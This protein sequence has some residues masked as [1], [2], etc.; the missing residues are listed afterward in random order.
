MGVERWLTLAYILAVA[1][2]GVSS[3]WPKLTRHY[4]P[5]QLQNLPTPSEVV[6]PLTPG[7]A[8][9]SQI[10]GKVN[11]NSASQ[12]E[13]ESLPGVGPALAGRIIDGRPYRSLEDLDRIKGVGPKMLERL[14]P[15]VSL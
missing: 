7:P 15:L 10:S 12:A 1:G 2:L 4:S 11:L 13:I 8:A 6:S 9:L 14:R 5:A 3:L